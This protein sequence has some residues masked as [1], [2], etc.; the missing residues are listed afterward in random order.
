MQWSGWTSSSHA[1]SWNDRGLMTGHGIRR[2][3]AGPVL[4]GRIT[5]E[6]LLKMNIVV[7]GDDDASFN[8]VEHRST[9]ATGDMPL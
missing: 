1:P 2:L 6:G 8:P 7:A 9:V 3:I 5:S 4:M